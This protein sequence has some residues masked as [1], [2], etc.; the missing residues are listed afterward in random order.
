[1]MIKQILSLGGMSIGIG[2]M[3][4]SAAQTASA[5]SAQQPGASKTAAAKTYTPPKTPWG[6]PDLQGIWPL[7]HLI[8]TP[9]QRQEKYGERRFMT[10]DEFAAAQKS[11]DARNKRFESGA[12]PQA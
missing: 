5:Q 6:E 7:N 3:V 9:F 10:D 1:M 2:L 8:S 11:A 12:I 4:C